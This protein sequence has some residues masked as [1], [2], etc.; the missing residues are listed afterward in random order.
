MHTKL[1]TIGIVTAAHFALYW[2]IFGTLMASDF[3]PFTFTFNTSAPPPHNS[4]AQ[5]FLWNIFQF[6]TYPFA[7]LPDVTWIPDHW[8]GLAVASLLNS[9]VWGACLALLFYVVRH[10]FQR[11][12]A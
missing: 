10:K 9:A 11:H 2:A 3:S 1:K 6:L 8:L 4:P 7:F 5:E 12:A